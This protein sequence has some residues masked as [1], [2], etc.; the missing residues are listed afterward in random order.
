MLYELIHTSANESKKGKEAQPSLWIAFVD[1]Y[2]MSLSPIL[3]L[4]ALKTSAKR[5]MVKDRIIAKDQGPPKV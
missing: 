5:I 2:V 4:R 1:R 3:T